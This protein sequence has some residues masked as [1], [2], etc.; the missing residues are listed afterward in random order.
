MNYVWLIWSIIILGLWGVVYWRNPEFRTE[1]WKMSWWTMLLGLSEPFFVSEYW[2]PPSLFDL[3]NKTGFDIE[4]LLFSF[5]IGG[6]GVVLYRL[7]YPSNLISVNQSEKKHHRHR[8]HKYILLTPLVVALLL[9]IFLGLNPIYC[10]VIA[11]FL[12]GLATLYC[13]PDLKSKIWIGGFLFTAL[14]FVYFGS[15]LLFFPEYVALYW[16]LEALT[17]ILI[18]GVP[19]E[20]LLFAFTFGMYWSGLYEHLFWY[21]LTSKLVHH[22]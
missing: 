22:E 10:G 9:K 18:L 16:N 21:Q 1:M 5:A 19:L 12:G 3:A 20:E 7:V 13:R 6:L 4:S 8:L 2:F 15:I 17:G 14:Y 11:L